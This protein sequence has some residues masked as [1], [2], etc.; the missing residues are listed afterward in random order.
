MTEKLEFLSPQ[1]LAMLHSKLRDYTAKLDAEASF[2]F[3]ESYR[4]VPRHLTKD[5]TDRLS[6]HM[7]FSDGK[8]HFV[9]EKNEDT[10]FLFEGD[11][12]YVRPL[13]GTVVTAANKADYEHAMAEGQRLGKMAHK[14]DLKKIP[15]ELQGLHNDMAALTK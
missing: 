7:L 13:A 1:W 11:Y 2:G 5:G 10:G 6:F 14:G 15:P 3:C 9:A 12:D 8:L 4:N